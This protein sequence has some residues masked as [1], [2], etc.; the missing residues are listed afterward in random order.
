VSRREDLDSTLAAIDGAL[1]D[2]EFPDAMRWSPEPETIDAPEPYDGELVWQPPQRYDPVRDTALMRMIDQQVVRSIQ[3]VV[4]LSTPSP[5]QAVSRVIA[6]SQRRGPTA[7]LAL[8][9][10]TFLVDPAH[11]EEV[12]AWQ[13]EE[14]QRIVRS[15]GE[16]F[17][18]VA[19]AFS[20]VAEQVGK[21]VAA[22][23]LTPDAPPRPLRETDPRAYALQ[24]RQARDT[25]PDRQVQR[26][27]R[28]RRH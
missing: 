28:P 4:V 22:I 18:D 11:R 16:W 17:T 2:A 19:E 21:A 5:V 12:R 23:R 7:D 26:Q 6:R 13:R 27:H 9:D 1:A 14:A 25:G 3:P 20:S 8:F 24:L 15:L 10:E